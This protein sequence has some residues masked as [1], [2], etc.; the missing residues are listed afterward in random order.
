MNE[1]ALEIWL[2]RAVHHQGVWECGLCGCPFAVGGVVANMACFG[3]GTEFVCPS[4][5]A[6]FG[7]RSPERFPTIQEYEGALRL[8]PEPMLAGREFGS[9]EEECLASDLALEAAGI[10]RAELSR[11]R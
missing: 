2:Q 9:W 5:V 6:Y 3:A 1:C 8:Y 11:T 7:R 4:C 10:D